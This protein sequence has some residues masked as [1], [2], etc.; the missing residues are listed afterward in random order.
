[1]N[2]VKETV[3][4]YNQLRDFRLKAILEKYQVDLVID[5]GANRGQF[6]LNLRKLGYTG[7]IFSFEPIAHIYAK[8]AA[9]AL[10]D[11]L[12]EVFDMALGNENGEKTINVANWSEFTSFLSSNE[13][14]E[15]RFGENCVTKASESVKIRKLCTVLAESI[16]KETNI[17][18]K[19]DTQGFDLEVYKGL[20]DYQQSVVALQSELSVVPIYKDIPHVTESLSFF[21]AQ[22]YALSS[23]YPITVEEA[24]LKTIEFDCMMVREDRCSATVTEGNGLVAYTE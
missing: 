3:G 21:E 12:W 4:Q 17:Y 16:S 6:A 18:L 9:E 10:H 11:D 15:E 22:G 1:M 2:E 5:A 14:C 24:T 23:I 8:L 20:G 19:L 7:R 13:W